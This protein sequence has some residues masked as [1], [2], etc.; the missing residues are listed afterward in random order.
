MTLSLTVILVE[1]TGNVTYGLPIMLVLMTSKI[2]GDY[3]IEVRIVCVFTSKAVI[4]RLTV[5]MCRCSYC[6]GLIIPRAFTI[7][8]SGCRVFLF[9]MG[10]LLPPPTG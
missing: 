2:V 10:K 7:S 6:C 1:A 4:S 8:T 9:S 3:F 5:Q